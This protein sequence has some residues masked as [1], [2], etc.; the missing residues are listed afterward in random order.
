MS[1]GVGP[2]VLTVSGPTF[3]ASGRGMFQ[4]ADDLRSWLDIKAYPVRGRWQFASQHLAD[5][6]AFLDYCN[7]R[8]RIAEAA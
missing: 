5:V 3:S 2:L 8:Y 6:A 7:V 1:R 4:V